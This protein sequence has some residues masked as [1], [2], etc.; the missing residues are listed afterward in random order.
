MSRR[1]TRQENHL[2]LDLSCAISEFLYH[3]TD[4]GFYRK[5]ELHI[6]DELVALVDRCLDHFDVRDDSPDWTPKERRAKL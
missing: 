5:D 1:L 4:R 3:N 2:A 6:R